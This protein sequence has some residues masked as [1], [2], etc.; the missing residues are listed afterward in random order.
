MATQLIDG[1]KISLEIQEE[2]ALEVKRMIAAGNKRPHL[3]AVL[4]GSDG[5]SETYVAS[6]IKTCE[7]V[8]F[9]SSDRKST[10]LN[11]SHLDLS[12]MPSSA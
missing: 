2:I 3:A 9:K 11:S 6:K 10:R 7:H 8:G 1:K 12:R 5:G 4:V